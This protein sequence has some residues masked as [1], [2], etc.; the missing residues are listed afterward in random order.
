MHLKDLFTSKSDGS[1]SVTKVFVTLA[2]AVF[3]LTVVAFCVRD[4]AEGKPPNLQ[5]LGLY[6]GLTILHASYD[7]TVAIVNAFKTDQMDKNL[8][9]G[10]GTTFAPTAPPGP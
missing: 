10:T 6:A 5:L 9:M 4:W 8:V 2:H 7:K 3:F 1:L